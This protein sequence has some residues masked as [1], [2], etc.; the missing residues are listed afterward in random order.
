MTKMLLADEKTI[1]QA[2]VKVGHLIS[3]NPSMTPD[4]LVPIM[5][6]SICFCADLL[7]VLYPRVNP[8]VAPIR[9]FR[10]PRVLAPGKF[11]VAADDWTITLPGGL[12]DK[13]VLL[14]DAVF[15]TGA[16]IQHAKEALATKQPRSVQSAVLIWKNLP[17]AIGHPD[18]WGLNLDGANH[19]VYG[20]GLDLDNQHRGAPTICY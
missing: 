16:T 9:M 8:M 7:R 2:V 19:Y 14:V 3:T 4:V 10:I 20:Y 15:D 5:S 18:Y 6:G 17:N 1:Y 11:Q 13:R 12:Q